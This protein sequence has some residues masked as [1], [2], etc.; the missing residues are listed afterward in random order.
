MRRRLIT[1]V[2]AGLVMALFVVPAAASEF[3]GDTEAADDGLVADEEPTYFL[4]YDYDPDAMV[5]LFGI[6][7]EDADEPLD[8]VLPDG[9]TAVVDEDTGEITYEVEGGGEFVLPEGCTA[10]SVEG[11][12]GQV[13]HGQ[14]VS[15]TVHALKDGYDKDMYGP[16]G[17]FV[18][19]VAG[20][21]ELGKGDQQVK[22][23][24]DDDGEALELEA[25]DDGESKPDKPAKPDKGKN[26]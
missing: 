26:K 19:D 17:Q 15:S 16:F 10:V 11:P 23:D 14:I 12:N 25:A 3:L 5:L 9:V 6:D 8:C 24:K 21:D 2:V 22:P 13:N 4:H 20:D 7:E 18:K 1:L